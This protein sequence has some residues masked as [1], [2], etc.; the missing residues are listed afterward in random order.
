MVV[1]DEVDRLSDID[2]VLLSAPL[3]R[4][5][6]FIQKRVEVYCSEIGTFPV[7][8]VGSV[9][10]GFANS[11]IMKEVVVE[12]GFRDRTVIVAVDVLVDRDAASLR[13]GL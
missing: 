4:S 1:K 6:H 3:F 5:T 7:Q 12:L 11:P 8:A 13:E 10:T 2:F 9:M